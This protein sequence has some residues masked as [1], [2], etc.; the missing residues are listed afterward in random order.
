MKNSLRY[1]HLLKCS[2]LNDLPDDQKVSFIDQ[3]AL[4]FYE[5][6]TPVLVQGETTSGLLLVAHGTIELAYLSQDGHKTIIH[7]A[8]PCEVVGEVEAIA[9]KPCAATCTALPNTAVLF[10][11][12]PLI[13][14]QLKSPVFVRNLAGIFYDRLV[15]DNKLKS[16]DQFYTVD[17][18]ICSYLSQ[19]SSKKKPLITQSQAYLANVVGC[20]RQT[21][22]RTLGVLRDDNIIALRKG[23]I[24]VLDRAALERRIQHGTA[25]DSGRIN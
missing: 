6:A 16:V 23:A 14:E 20:S 15:R 4:R 17:Q 19:L 18:R 10:C 9:D 25:P 12:T 8:S 24:E 21:I 7:L 1:P 13:F 3:C 5:T 11:A 22:N 2:L